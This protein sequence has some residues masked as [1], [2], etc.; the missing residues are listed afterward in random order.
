MTAIWMGLT[1]IDAEVG[2]GRLQLT[3]DP[4]FKTRMQQWLRLSP[5]AAEKKRVGI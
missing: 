2:A 1:T 5:F 3:G 4:T